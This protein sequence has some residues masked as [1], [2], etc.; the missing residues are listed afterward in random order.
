MLFS[1]VVCFHVTSPILNL[2]LVSCVWVESG[3][4]GMEKTYGLVKG[5]HA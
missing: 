2:A 5:T 4:N 1:S 3:Q